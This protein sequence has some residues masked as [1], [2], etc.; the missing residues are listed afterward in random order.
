[1]NK[2]PRKLSRLMWMLSAASGVSRDA[3]KQGLLRHRPALQQRFGTEAELMISI[4]Q[5]ND[6][7]TLIG[8]SRRIETAEAIMQVSYPDGWPEAGL[9][10]SLDGLSAALADVVDVGK[11]AMVFGRAYLLLESPGTAFCGFVGR[12]DPGRT[13]DEMRHWWLHHHAP[14]AQ[15]LTGYSAHGYDQLHVDRDASQRLCAAAGFPFVPYD[16]ADCIDIPDQ[17]AFLSATSDPEIG[18]QLYE[19]EVGF[20][21]HSSWRG[22]FTDK[23]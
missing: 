8:G 1:M 20:L 6:P 15:S 2:E 19:D 11:S 22:A 9:A 13:V 12:R 7:F 23:L 18:R 5:A 4:Q 3:L 21:D 10:K 14:L 17:A 16:M